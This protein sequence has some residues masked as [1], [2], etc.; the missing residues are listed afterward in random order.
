MEEEKH[1]IKVRADMFCKL[2]AAS[3]GVNDGELLEISKSGNWLEFKVKIHHQEHIIRNTQKFE[4][5]H[6]INVE[7]VDSG[8]KTDNWVLSVKIWDVDLV[9]CEG[10]KAVEIDEDTL[11]FIY[12]QFFSMLDIT[13]GKPENITLTDFALDEYVCSFMEFNF[14]DEILAVDTEVMKF[15]G[16]KMM[17]GV[18]EKKGVCVILDEDENV[19]PFYKEQV[20]EF[21]EKGKYYYVEDDDV[22]GV[23]QEE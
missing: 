7:L 3:C 4:E 15:V 13:K 23:H 16:I 8:E 10:F 12:V 11:K 18:A 22:Y 1:K 21:E 2:F 9:G 6:D 17:I 14:Y 19:Y 20:E 5:Q